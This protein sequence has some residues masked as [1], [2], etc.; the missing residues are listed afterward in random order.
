M[1]FRYSILLI[2]ALLQ[3]FVISA[4][5][6]NTYLTEA[7]ACKDRALYTEAIALYSEAMKANDDYR[8]YT[9]RGEAFLMTGNTDAAINDFLQANKLEQGSGYLGL[10]RAYAIE[11]ETAKAIVNLRHHLQSDFR[12]PRKEILLDKYLSSLEETSEWRQLWKTKWYNQLEEAIAEIEYYV[13]AGKVSEAEDILAGVESLYREQAGILYAKGII[14]AASNKSTAALDYLTRAVAGDESDYKTWKLYI[15]QLAKA[16]NYISASNACDR[17]L[18][19]FPEHTELILMKSDYLRKA[20]DRNRALDAAERYLALY[21][22]DEFSNRQAGIIA[23]EIGE[24]NK[25]LRYFSKNIENYPGKAQCFADR[26]D[27]YL[28]IKSWDAAVYDYSMALDL[29]P[30]DGNTYYNKGLA[31]INSGKTEEACHDFRMALRYGNRKAAG[32]LS[33]YCIK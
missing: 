28:K 12:L 11:N 15:E 26:G 19:S 9:G 2:F 24:Y 3:A 30:R 22:D 27:I 7:A 8:L 33:K 31:L 10:A 23:G 13:K 29:W 6:K 4:Q 25:A 32:M 5:D 21:P 16:G 18:S 17:A 1:K 14:L 20:N